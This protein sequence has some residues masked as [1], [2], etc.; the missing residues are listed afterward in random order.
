MT[1]FGQSAGSMAAQ[2]LLLSGQVA[3]LF[4]GAILQSGPILSAFAHSD[5]NPAYYAKTFSASVGCDP[6]RS[7][8]DI[9]ECL[10][11]LTAEEIV[12]QVRVLDHKDNIMLNA[13]NPC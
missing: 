6:T 8:S 7:S 13:P 11:Q 10:Q 4:Q 3:G 2:L 1:L 9:L 5:K 12:S